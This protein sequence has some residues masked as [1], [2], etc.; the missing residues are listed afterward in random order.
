M[1]LGSFLLLLPY[2]G[3]PLDLHTMMNTASFR[4][5]FLGFII[6]GLAYFIIL[7]IKATK[8]LAST[9][10]SNRKPLLATAGFIAINFL[11]FIVWFI[12]LIFSV[13]GVENINIFFNVILVLIF[14]FGTRNPDYFLRISEQAERL[15]YM[16]TLIAGVDTEKTLAEI[17]SLMSNGK[18]Y[19]DPGLCLEMLAKRVNLSPQ[20]LSELL[21]SKA[22]KN[23]LEFVNDYRV[24]EAKILLLNDTE[25][26][27]ID[28]AFDV[29]FNSS[30]A[31][32]NSFK[33]VAGMTPTK[34]RESYPVRSSMV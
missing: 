23:F 22:A 9:A 3:R 26:K 12:D 16:R 19:H 6:T 25:R 14:L 34:Y 18:L 13:G 31:F 30:S 7:L 27:I 15:K 21:N 11:V 24:E 29:G 32:Y 33:K 20:Q 1:P 8:L 17:S 5:G 4:I 28:I 2:I 10:N